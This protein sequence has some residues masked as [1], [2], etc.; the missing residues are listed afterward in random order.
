[1]DALEKQTTNPENSFSETSKHGKK[2]SLPTLIASLLGLFVIT[3]DAVIVN[4]ALPTMGL[5][6][7]GGVTGLQWIVD[8]Y[9]LM[10]AA[11]LLFSGALSDR[12]GAGR[13]FGLGLLVFVLAS[14]ACGLAPNLN[15]MV[16]ARFV[17]GT[18]AAIMMP[19]S[20]A[21]IGQAYPDPSKRAGAVAIWAMGGAIASSS[22][23][24]L[25]GLLSQIDWRLIFY[26]NIP[27]G[28]G[29][30]FLLTRT[31]PS[32]NRKVPFDWIG[33]VT[34]VLA[35]GG[36]TFG[37]IEAGAQGITS[38]PVLG[39]FGIAVVALVIFVLAQLRGAHPMVPPNLFKIRNALIANIAGFAFMVG[40]FGLP[41][42]MSLYLQQI[43][44]LSSL[45]TGMAFL[46]M[47][48]IGAILTPFSARLAK[49]L[50]ARTLI[51]TGLALMTVGLAILAFLSTTTP[52]WVLSAL[53][54]LV[55]LAGPFVSPPM[56]AVLL[57][58]VSE[59]QAGTASG[60][61]NT[62][63]QIGGALA[64]AVFG[65]LLAKPETFMQGVRIS[66]LL[67]AGVAFF[68]AITSL[69]LEETPR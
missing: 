28:A 5:E 22:A 21:L 25:G 31:E 62:S 68:T 7:G 24:V 44:G 69:K 51:T 17:Q 56:T 64:V 30:L 67:A 50:G 9:T 2:G 18:G 58:S 45:A 27:V 33:Q 1:M 29:A 6:L 47:M 59:D 52:I 41:F 12:I 36:I 60:I 48:L 23:P 53:M 35:M 55:G 11:L 46:P 20:M 49:R 32:P 26:I 54:I 3:L 66:L 57:N 37:A 13:T 65:A 39:A 4:V 10:F 63:R 38:P 43:R 40:Y 34:A 14:I 15:A 61:F 8:G 19:S 16:I 42:V